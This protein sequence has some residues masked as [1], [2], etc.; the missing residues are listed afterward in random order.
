MEYALLK[1]TRWNEPNSLG[2]RAPAGGAHSA[3]PDPLAVLGEGKRRGEEGTRRQGKGM[4]GDSSGG[5][6]KE[7]EGI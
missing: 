1:K 7:A 2:G 6:G 4:K 5:E 3:P